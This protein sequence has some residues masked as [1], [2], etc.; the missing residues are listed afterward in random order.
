M[1]ARLSA[2]L[3]VVVVTPAVAQQQPP[4]A[5]PK[6]EL[7][8]GGQQAPTRTF[9]RCVDVEIGGAR[10]YGC[11]NETLRRDVDK[12]APSLNLPPIDARSSDTK[13]GIVNI[14]AVQQQYGS[15]FGRSVVPFRVPQPVFGTT[16]RQ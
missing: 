4:A 14:P 11:L 12:V 1:I 10:S 9:E 16:P 3:L 7:I 15:N 8:I 5:E 6:P 2:L 13:L